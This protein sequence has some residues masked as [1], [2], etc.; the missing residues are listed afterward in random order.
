MAYKHGVYVT[1]QATSIVAPIVGTAGLQVVFGTAPVNQ[2]PYNTIAGGVVNTPIL[3][4]TY[5][6]AVQKL[7]FSYSFKDYTLCESIYACFQVVGVSPIVL[8]NVLDPAKHR[9]A[10]TSTELTVADGV[11]LLDEEG[12]L[13]DTLAVKND[14]TALVSGTDYV[15]EFNDD[16]TVNIALVDSERLQA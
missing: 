9:T 3:A 10:I 7:G 1:E 5:K 4:Y 11:A 12:V 14:D 2:V 13:C 15:T 6:E 8:I 16:G